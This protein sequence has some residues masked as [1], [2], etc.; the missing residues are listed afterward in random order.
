MINA[1]KN[2]KTYVGAIAIAAFINWSIPPIARVSEMARTLRYEP[3][4]ILVMQN[5]IEEKV[6][7]S[8]ASVLDYLNAATEVVGFMYD[9][10]GKIACVEYG[11]AIFDAYQQLVIVNGRTELSDRIRV[12]ADMKKKGGHLWIEYKD[13]DAIVQYQFYPNSSQDVAGTRTM[14]GTKI[15]YPTNDALTRFSGLVGILLSEE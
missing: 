4:P 12:C 13:G 2:K 11:R 14:W 3:T 15:P 6:L 1:I 8:D 9:P 5:K 7:A 10:E